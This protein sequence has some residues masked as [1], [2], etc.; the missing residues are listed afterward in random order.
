M[1]RQGAW[2]ATS[3]CLALMSCLKCLSALVRF[4]VGT[5]HLGSIPVISLAC[6]RTCDGDV[7]S[8]GGDA[9]L[10]SHRWPIPAVCAILQLTQ[11]VPAESGKGFRSM[12][13][14]F[15]NHPIRT[16]SAKHARRLVVVPSELANRV[17]Q[18][19]TARQLKLREG[20]SRWGWLPGPW[21]CRSDAD[22]TVA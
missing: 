22:K 11:P 8:P 16:P 19:S 2:L 21:R 18:R 17:T 6:A 9:D 3:F 5:S 1:A 13:C 7:R 4:P 20:E 15:K 12:A 14:A 10:L